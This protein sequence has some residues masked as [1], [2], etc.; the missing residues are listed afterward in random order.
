MRRQRAH[1]C[2]NISPITRVP[3]SLWRVAPHTRHPRPSPAQQRFVLLRFELQSRGNV[4]IRDAHGES[5]SI[6]IPWLKCAEKSMLDASISGKQRGNLPSIAPRLKRL[7]VGQV[8]LIARET[9]N[10]SETSAPLIK[11]YPDY[12]PRALQKP[13][14]SHSAAKALNVAVCNSPPDTKIA[15]NVNV[16]R[17]E[18]RA[19]TFIAK[20]VAK[21]RAFVS[22]ARVRLVA[23]RRRERREKS[24]EEKS[25]C[26]RKHLP[27]M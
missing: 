21:I 17:D 1:P 23:S 3:D 22:R 18:A 13:I 7:V 20:C 25:V 6:V 11:L 14:R 4:L 2:D 10:V 5:V 15:F 26:A 16:K 24:D 12:R 8:Y 9:S 27:A 19:V